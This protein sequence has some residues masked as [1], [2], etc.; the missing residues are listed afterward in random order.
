MAAN[1]ELGVELESQDVDKDVNRLG[2]ARSKEP[3]L[4][5]ISIR[6]AR[7]PGKIWLVRLPEREEELD[8]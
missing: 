3:A 4:R 2:Q 8:V 5:N 7:E 1:A 6:R